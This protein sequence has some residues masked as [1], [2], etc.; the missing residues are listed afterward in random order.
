M[1]MNRQ[2]IGLILAIVLAVFLAGISGLG[3]LM[4]GEEVLANFNNFNLVKWRVIIGIGEISSAILFA[5]P[6]TKNLGTW[7]LSSYFG[8]A[9]LL[10]MT[11]DQPIILPV[12]FLVLIW[13]IA[14]VRG[15]NPIA[16]HK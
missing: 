4:G 2:T 13:A 10:H 6:Q 5:I 11:T 7:L 3:K 16:M 9:I 1:K 12:I 15:A 14:I 8:G